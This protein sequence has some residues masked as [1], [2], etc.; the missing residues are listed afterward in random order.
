MLC[1]QS[2]ACALFMTNSARDLFTP[3]ANILVAD[4]L[5][6]IKGHLC[7]SCGAVHC[8]VATDAL[9][10]DPMTHFRRGG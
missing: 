5:L 2:D 7:E 10:H 6:L 9:Q 1:L 3:V 4:A 8:N